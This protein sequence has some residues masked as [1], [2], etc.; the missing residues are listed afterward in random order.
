M[1]GRLGANG[2]FLFYS[3]SRI[4]SIDLQGIQMINY[5]RGFNTFHTFH[6]LI[7]LF[8]VKKLLVFLLE[9]NSENQLLNKFGI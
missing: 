4:E 6:T 1:T 5:W 3:S 8:L 2:I 9:S 7:K